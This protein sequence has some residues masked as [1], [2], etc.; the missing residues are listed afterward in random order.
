ML[1]ISIW[2][3]LLFILSGVIIALI[4]V[5][6]GA[7]ITYRSKVTEPGTGF[8]TGKAPQGEVFTIP[9]DGQ[10]EEVPAAVSARN[11]VFNNLFGGKNEN[12]M[13]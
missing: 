9:T 5:F 11:R 3:L 2:Q 6:V 13:S 12:T 4:S 1:Q 8:L 7:F 10:E